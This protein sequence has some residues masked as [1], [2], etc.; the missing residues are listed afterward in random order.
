MMNEKHFRR[1]G[2]SRSVETTGKTVDEAIQAALRRLHVRRENIDIDILDEGRGGF[3]GIGARE[4][5]IRARVKPDRDPG[6]RMGQARGDDRGSRPRIRGTQ[7]PRDDQERPR[8]GRIQEARGPE[9]GA[10]TRDRMPDA[11]DRM[12]DS[13][14]R[15]ADS[16]DRM[17]DTRDRGQEI[18]GQERGSET[19]DRM[20]DMRAQ[21]RSERGERGERGQERGERLDRGERGER[22]ERGGERP[23]ARGTDSSRRRDEGGHGTRGGRTSSLGSI[24][25]EIRV[26]R[27]SGRRT[28]VRSEDR[29]RS[30]GGRETTEDRP[31]VKVVTPSEPIDRADLQVRVPRRPIAP[32]QQP[33]TGAPMEKEIAEFARGLLQR[34]GFSVTVD[35]VFEDGAY[36]V[37]IAGSDNDAVLIGRRGETMEALQHVLAKMAS[38][39]REDLV[40]VRVDV[41][42]YRARRDGELAERAL[43][44]AQQVRDTG[45]E[46][47][48]EALPAAERRIVHRTLSE[49]TDVK[50][51]A[52]GEGL[53]KRIWIGPIDKEIPQE[54]AEA[55][56]MRSFHGGEPA[57]LTV[58]EGIERPRR[59]T[60]EAIPP[61]IPE[62]AS[63][64]DF[65]G[66]AKSSAP[67]PEWGRKPKPAKGRR[68]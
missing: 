19:R 32:E 41:S 34:M 22:V 40:R 61:A 17:A 43:E 15:T 50:T 42:D 51:Q 7:S 36:E 56:P 13:R 68:R 44:W 26:D 10:E 63:F 66:D 3:L 20:P 9:R 2:P 1:S 35:A 30:R 31:K 47:I 62:A 5:K 49:S 55:R 37:K 60:V 18:R 52:L 14:D 33:D 11:R 25:Q 28:P 45:Q 39:G 38:R 64:D 46:I 6:G 4:A 27:R 53:V 48:T 23:E 21:E 58:T 12:P 59:E 29:P 57:P 8:G 67:A 24:G 16:R 54:P 65:T